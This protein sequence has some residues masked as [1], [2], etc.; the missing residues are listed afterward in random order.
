MKARRVLDNELGPN[1]FRHF[2]RASAISALS[3]GEH[4][5]PCQRWVLRSQI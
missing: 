3:L 5:E 2:V 4:W 1:L